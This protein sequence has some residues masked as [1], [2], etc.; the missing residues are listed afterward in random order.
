M[1]IYGR[2]AS[3][4]DIPLALDEESFFKSKNEISKALLVKR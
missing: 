3:N 1:S 4:A 2:V